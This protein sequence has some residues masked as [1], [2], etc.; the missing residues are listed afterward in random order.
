MLC[1]GVAPHSCAFVRKGLGAHCVADAGQDQELICR[2]FARSAKDRH[3]RMGQAELWCQ[4]RTMICPTIP[5][6]SCSTHLYW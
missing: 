1:F 2:P 5:S 6:S 3:P 4:G